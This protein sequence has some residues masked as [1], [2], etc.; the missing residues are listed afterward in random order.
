MTRFSYEDIKER[1]IEKF[2]QHGAD[3]TTLKNASPLIDVY[4]GGMRGSSE[5]LQSQFIKNN[6]INQIS[7]NP[8]DATIHN[9]FDD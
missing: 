2:K 1:I 7:I 3:E 6:I 8:S 4:I 5:F 9:Y